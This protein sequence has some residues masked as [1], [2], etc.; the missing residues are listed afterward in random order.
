[1]VNTIDVFHPV[2]DQHTLRPDNYGSVGHGATV[3]VAVVV[4][5]I[6]S[7]IVLLLVLLFLYVPLAA[8]FVSRPRLHG[9]ARLFLQ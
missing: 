1:M 8:V 6:V 2:A 5:V 3:V 7:V 9:R 4:V